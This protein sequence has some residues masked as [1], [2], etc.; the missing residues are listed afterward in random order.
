[1]KT[2]PEYARIAY[3]KSIVSE[4]KDHLRGR[5]LALSS[6]NPE[7][8]ILCTDVFSQDS[9]VPVEEVQ[10]VVEELEQ[11]EESLRLQLARFSFR[12]QDENNGLLSSTK[13]K[14]NGQAPQDT[15]QRGRHPHK[16]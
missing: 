6:V 15:K 16:K 13:K 14:N 11:E 2:D 5:Y 7:D 1:M 8:T 12:K 9:N 10:A 3:R 4:L